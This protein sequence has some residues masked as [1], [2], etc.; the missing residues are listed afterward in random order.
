MTIK[1]YLVMELYLA[2]AVLA[3]ELYLPVKTCQAVELYLTVGL[4]LTAEMHLESG[5]VLSLI[6][7]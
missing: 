7:I 1:R 2:Q 4:Y 5:L 6:H 3:M